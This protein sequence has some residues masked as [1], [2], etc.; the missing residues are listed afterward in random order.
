MVRGCD[1][2]HIHI[3]AGLKSCDMLD[4]FACTFKCGHLQ[5]PHVGDKVSMSLHHDLKFQSASSGLNTIDTV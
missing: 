3:S 1:S 5:L 2:Q 4:R